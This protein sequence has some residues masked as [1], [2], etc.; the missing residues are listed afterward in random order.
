MS[1]LWDLQGLKIPFEFIEENMYMKVSINKSDI[2]GKMYDVIHNICNY[3]RI[4]IL[5]NVR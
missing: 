4:I 3:S 1:L 5:R 2:N